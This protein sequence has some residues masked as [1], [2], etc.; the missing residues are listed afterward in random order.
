[1]SEIHSSEE[2]RVA[3][4]QEGTPYG[5]QVIERWTLL[6]SLIRIVGYIFLVAA[7][8]ALS[9]ALGAGIAITLEYL[10]GWP[11]TWAL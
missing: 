6:R 5:G 3:T 2:E 1:M 10:L 11:D 8:F 4:A 9:L 7:V